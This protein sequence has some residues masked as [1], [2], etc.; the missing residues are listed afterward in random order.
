VSCVILV[1]VKD[2]AF[3]KSRMGPFLSAEERSLVATAM[4]DDLIRALLPL[5]FPVAVVTNSQQI[6]TRIAKLG[7]RVLWEEEQLSES[8]SIDA[9]S[10]R[11]ADEGAQ[12]VLR[13][14]ADLPL[15]QT[16]D[17]T[18]L[19]LETPQ[20]P[21]AV[22][23]PSWDGT[24]TNALLRTPPNLFP[25]HFGPGSFALH[26]ENARLVGAQLRVVHNSRLALDLDDVADIARF[27]SSPTECE[28][29]R[30]LMDLNVKERLARHAFP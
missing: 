27:L 26:T 25:S 5:V 29:Y 2:R 20:A 11:L 15:I 8:S 24:G 16:D 13:L 4:L 18:E 22:L 12:A 30:T 7:W 23:A 9:A 14:P 6:A 10:T 19:C 17:V 21:S 1:P 3:A 28:T